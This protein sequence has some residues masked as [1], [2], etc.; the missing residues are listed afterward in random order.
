MPMSSSV[1]F[2]ATIP[3]PCQQSWNEMIPSGNGKHCGSCQKK[4]IDFSMLTDAE[5]VNIF[6]GPSQEIC[7]RFN[8]SQLNRIL[9]KPAERKNAF[10]TVVLTT[11]LVII[12]PS[13]SAASSAAV[14]FVHAP[15][16]TPA[17]LSEV[18]MS[19]PCDTPRIITGQLID[20]I[21]RDGLPACTVIIKGTS[22]STLTDVAGNF[23]LRVPDSLQHREITLRFAFIGFMTKEL[24]VEDNRP[25]KV[26][27]NAQVMGELVITCM[28]K[29]TFRGRV[30]ATWKRLW[31]K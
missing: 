5:I 12:G 15:F 9:D 24:L 14:P 10:P 18:S 1:T 27:L 8:S 13:K 7:G 22:Y 3:Q 31:G 21:H 19:Q 26:E 6:S 2:S 25:L 4:V 23:R 20:S 17:G 16:A 30:K 11:L 28:R 29:T